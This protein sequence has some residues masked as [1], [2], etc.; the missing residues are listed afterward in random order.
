M[1]GAS[2]AQAHRAVPIAFYVALSAHAPTALARNPSVFIFR[3]FLSV[4]CQF[5]SLSNRPR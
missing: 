2:P 3:F 4:R 1:R 5:I